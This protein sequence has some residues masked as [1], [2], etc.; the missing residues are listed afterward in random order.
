MP[1][2][3]AGF[4]VAPIT[5]ALSGVTVSGLIGAVPSALAVLLTGDAVVDWWASDDAA[6]DIA[7]IVNKRMAAAGIDLQFPPFNPVT[8]EGKAIVKRTL[9]AF[10]VQRINARA[11]TEFANLEGLNQE[12][13]LSEVGRAI[14]SQVNARTGSNLA[15][16][17]PVDKL[18]GEL[19]T[20][21][22]RQFEN[23]GRYAGGSLFKANSLAQIK[24]KIAGKYPVLFKAVEAQ[25]DGGYWGPPKD[26]KQKKRREAGR[27]RQERYRATH[28]QVWIQKP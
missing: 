13:F 20:E 15:S 11:G 7:E 27:I 9:E 2:F 17:W 21:V 18:Q 10:A 16:V 14:A 25:R 22:L 6:A 5:A 4:F 1:I 3:L 24:T 28:Q 26:E 23:R 19:K 8:S 12:V